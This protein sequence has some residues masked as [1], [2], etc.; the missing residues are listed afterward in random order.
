MP[1]S[2]EPMVFAKEGDEEESEDTMDEGSVE[3]AEGSTDG[4]VRT[5]LS[6][7]MPPG[8]P[9]G[10]IVDVIIWDR[11]I[12]ELIHV[13][14][15]VSMPLLSACGRHSFCHHQP[16]SEGEEEDLM[17]RD[18]EC[19]GLGPCDA[20]VAY[21]RLFRPFATPRLELNYTGK[22]DAQPTQERAEIEVEGGTFIMAYLREKQDSGGSQ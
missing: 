11:V 4:E 21:T 6:Y 7:V 14:L 20:G 1:P 19:Y 15:V 12:Q 9:G 17:D 2:V 18:G 3:E 16:Q 10:H 13:S 22:V 5:D 8:S